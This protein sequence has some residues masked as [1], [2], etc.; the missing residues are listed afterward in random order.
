MFTQTL[1]ED[2][3]G[4]IRSPVALQSN[5][6]L[7]GVLTTLAHVVGHLCFC[8]IMCCK[9][10]LLHTECQMNLNESNV[11]TLPNRSPLLPSIPLSCVSITLTNAWLFYIPFTS[12]INAQVF[13]LVYVLH[14]NGNHKG[15]MFL[16]EG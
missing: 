8:P 3:S 7:Q 6:I 5:L 2:C 16:Q 14:L 11:P 10:L 12:W 9:F 1:E 4:K 13:L 15:R